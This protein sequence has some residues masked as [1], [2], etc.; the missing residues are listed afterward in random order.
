MT[1]KTFY[2]KLAKAMREQKAE[3]TLTYNCVLRIKVPN[4]RD[5]FCPITLVATNEFDEVCYVWEAGTMG[6]KLGLTEE[7]T[8]KIINAADLRDP[9]HPQISATLWGIVDPPIFPRNFD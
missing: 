9:F 4:I 2:K 7:D 5:E 8:I 6:K 3:G 1:R